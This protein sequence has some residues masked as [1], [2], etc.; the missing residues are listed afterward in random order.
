[1]FYDISKKTKR[2]TLRQFNHLIKNSKIN[3]Y[4]I[5]DLKQMIDNNEAT[6]CNIADFKKIKKDGK[7]FYTCNSLDKKYLFEQHV[8][9][10]V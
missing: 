9:F 3:E 6:F 10:I 2:E 5:D 8:S 4:L 7:S 1:M